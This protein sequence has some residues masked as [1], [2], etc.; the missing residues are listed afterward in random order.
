MA[1]SMRPQQVRR[2]GDIARLLVKHGRGEAAGYARDRLSK[3]GAGHPSTS[4]AER[5][6]V[7]DAEELAADLERR[8]PT[9]VKLGQ[10]LST[11]TDLLPGP[12]LEALSRLQERCVPLPFRAVAAVVQE[13]FGRPIDEVFASFDTIPL[14]SASLGQVHRARLSDGQVVAVKVQRPDVVNGI[15]EDLDAIAE[16]AALA[17]RHTEAGKRFGF[18]PMVDE[19]RRSMLAELDY[20]REAANL[21]LL[22]R[23]L[24]TFDRIVI[25]QPVDEYCTGRVLTM[26]FVDGRPVSATESQVDGP[27][28]AE[29]LAGAYLHQIIEDGF[30]HADPH[31]GIVRV[32][33]DGRLAL[34]DVGMAARVTRP[35]RDALLQLFVAMSENDGEEAAGAAIVL[36]ERRD[37][38]E[39][40]EAAFVRGVTELVADQHALA[41]ERLSPG[42]VLCEISRIAADTGLRPRPELT[43]LGKALLNLDEVARRLDPDFVPTEA[44]RTYAAGLLRR[45][46]VPTPGRVLA[47]TMDAKEFAE[48]LPGRFNKV[49]DA[50]ARGELTLNVQGVD[51]ARILQ[52]IQRLANR[53]AS[54][55]LL[56]ALVVGAAMMMQIETPARL[57]GYPAVAIVCFILA[58][59][60]G[61][62]L[63]AR[64][65]WTDRRQ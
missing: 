53:L 19:F 23:N 33:A 30:F 6:M 51:E 62:G 41:V 63:L 50:L 21:R 59:G 5:E 2:Y 12:Y 44:V 35:T 17:D 34:L 7:A 4:E 45:R 25:P 18:S 9:F 39:F 36:G 47:A 29:T 11:R 42:T 22:G 43:M 60:G 64:I 27:A 31:P 52:G 49:M 15:V 26:E 32:T 14:A 61:F 24:S 37:D 13:E 28:L 57:F 40:D 55:L 38:C 48:E 65:L 16:I 56:A 46:L 54:A 58:A 20:C 10:L 8:G 3:A 1:I